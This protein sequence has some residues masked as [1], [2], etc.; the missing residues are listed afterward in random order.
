MDEH[1]RQFLVTRAPV[2]LPEFRQIP[3]SDGWILYYSEELPVYFD[4]A[5]QIVLL[6]L[7]WQALPGRE[8]PEQELQHLSIDGSGRIPEE[9]LLRA[10]ESWAGRYVLLSG[11]R[12]YLDPVGSLGV[13]Y[14]DG[15][16]IS[17]SLSLLARTMG[18]E[19]PRYSP[20]SQLNWCPAPMTADPKILRLLPS[21]V[22]ELSTGKLLPRRLLA[23]AHPSAKDEET[24]IQRFTEI[25]CQ[26]LQ[27]MQKLLSPRKLLIALTGGLDSRTLLALCS[28]AGLELQGF[29]LEHPGIYDGDLEIPPVLCK[30]L[31]IPYL[32]IPRDE[33]RYD[34]K[35][36]EAYEAFLSGMARDQDR[37]YYA[38]GQYDELIRQ[39]GGNAAILRSHIWAIAK[40]SYRRYFKDPLTLEDVLALYFVNRDSKEGDALVQYLDWCRQSPQP[41][42]S[43]GNRFYWEQRL[44]CWMAESEHGFDLY[45][46]LV[47]LNPMNCRLLITML[48]DFPEQ[49]RSAHRH[50]V[51]ITQ[52]ACP[53]IGQIPYGSKRSRTRRSSEVLQE[54][55]SRGLERLR[56]NG[57]RG[58]L[59]IYGKIVKDMVQFR[60]GKP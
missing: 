19:E 56:R 22:Y 21:Q 43:D 18:R 10:E 14:A 55:L 24:L 34:A 33:K 44:A 5:R 6:G 51:R 4:P 31:G 29:T 12:A 57:L 38:Y 8:S 25:Y 48:L 53:Q 23:A 47:S 27:N 16:G 2:S 32:T 36:E 35:R 20:R 60:R 28:G 46:N 1:R 42:L 40:N 17:S 59:R 9:A 52:F 39:C 50:Q 3:L 26:S 13:F 49:E 37:L 45:E 58:T 41:G 30:E 7:A 54:K 15:F 11:G